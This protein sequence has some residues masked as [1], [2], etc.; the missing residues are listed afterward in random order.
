MNGD[1][2]VEHGDLLQWYFPFERNCFDAAGF[3]KARDTQ[4]PNPTTN[5]L[6]IPGATQ[7]VEDPNAR[8]RQKHHDKQYGNTPSH[9]KMVPLLKAYREDE[10]NP[11]LYD[12]HRVFARAMCTARP[13]ER[14][15]IQIS[16][17]SA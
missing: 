3:R 7:Y 6:V 9:M 1:F 2:A 8:K 11:R 17:Q 4:N 12:W 15:D 10:E 16:R 5:G 13:N 14:F